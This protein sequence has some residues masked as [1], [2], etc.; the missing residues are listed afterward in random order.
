[1]PGN[2]RAT[3]TPIRRGEAAFAAAGEDGASR[4]NITEISEVGDAHRE[5]EPV[6]SVGGADAMEEV[7]SACRASAASTRFKRSSSAAR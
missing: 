6:E 4:H 5:E 1:M 3:G 7:P 2:E